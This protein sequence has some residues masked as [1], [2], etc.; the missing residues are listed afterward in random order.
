MKYEGRKPNQS[1]DVAN[2]KVFCGQTNG[3]TDKRNGQKLYAAD[4]LGV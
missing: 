1:K 2:V 4:L 3:R